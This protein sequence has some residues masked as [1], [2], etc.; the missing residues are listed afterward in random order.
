MCSGD[1]GVGEDVSPGRDVAVGGQ[2]D[3][4][5]LVAAGDDLEQSSRV[6]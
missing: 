3:G 5:L 4:A 1:G 2:D 6:S